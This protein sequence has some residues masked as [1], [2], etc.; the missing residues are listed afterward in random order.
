MRLYQLTLNNIDT[1]LKSANEVFQSWF[2]SIKETL[3][4]SS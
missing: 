1:E 2:Q 3:R 4:S